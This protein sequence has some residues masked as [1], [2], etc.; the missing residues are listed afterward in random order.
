[1]ELVNEEDNT[2]S[3][4]ELVHSILYPTLKK[5]HQAEQVGLLR[6]LRGYMQAPTMYKMVA[7]FK[8]MDGFL[9]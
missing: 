1:M 8:F 7:F 2:F 5:L 9:E 4:K 3:A 6:V